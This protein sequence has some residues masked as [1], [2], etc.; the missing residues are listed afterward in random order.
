LATASFDGTTKLWDAVSGQVVLSLPEAGQAAAVRAVAF[1]PKGKRVATGNADG[2]AA[3]WLLESSSDADATNGQKM[4]TLS[5][6]A[7]PKSRV[8]YNGVTGVAFS[9]DGTRLATASDDGTAKVWLLESGSAGDASTGQELLTLFAH[10]DES[11]GFTFDGVI[12]VVFSPDGKRLATAGAD[13]T[14]K[15]WDA[16]TGRELL[17]LSGHTGE[18][19]EITFSPDGT[20]LATSSMD[21]T[22]KLWN[23]TTGQELLTLAGHTSPVFGVAFSPDGTRLATSSDSGVTK[24][25]NAATGQVLLTL[26]NP[27]G[28]QRIAFSPDGKHLAIGG[29]DGNVR[30]YILPIEELVALAQSRV[31]RSLTTEECQRFLHKDECPAGP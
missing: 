24:V 4:L 10:P 20:H 26:S 23:A 19:T 2:T 14:A 8:S 27:I 15:V 16:I 3:V 31:T 11:L 25:W 22:A 21:S 18:L 9:P 1:G 13:G 29:Q 17:T 30:F 5:G 28:F 7:A 12:R 6:H